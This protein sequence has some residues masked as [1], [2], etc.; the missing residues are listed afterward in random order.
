MRTPLKSI[1]LVLT[2][3]SFLGASSPSPTHLF[4]VRDSIEMVRFARRN[5]MVIFSPD[6]K[7]FAIVTSRGII[8]SNE[9][10]STIWV[11]AT[12]AVLAFVRAGSEA[13]PPAPTVAARWSAIPQTEYFDSYEPV[14]SDLQWL[15]DSTSLLY[16][17]QNSYAEH[18]VYIANIASGMIRPL[19]PRGRDVTK[20]ELHYASNG[21]SVITYVA[22]PSRVSISNGDRL[23]AD[24]SDVTGLPLWQI[25]FPREEY[26]TWGYP[27]AARSYVSE[28]RG[29]KRKESTP[30][31]VS[32]SAVIKQNLNIP[33]ALWVTDLRT[34]K[35]KKLWDPNPHFTAMKFGTASIF[36]WRDSSGYEW[37][38]G[39][40]KPPDYIPGKRYPLVIQT[41]GFI[42]NEFMTDGVFTTAFAA[43]PLASAG[44]VVLE[45]GWNPNHFI[46]AQEIPDQIRGF[47]SA[48]DRLTSIGLVDRKRVGI[49]GFSRTCYHVEGALINDPQLF[50]AASI[51]D[52]VDESYVQYLLWG[53]SMQPL[54]KQAAN[55]SNVIYGA[56]PFGKGLLTWAKDTLGFHLN[57]IQTP[58]LIGALG[59]DSILSEWEIYSSLRMQKKPVDLIYIPD[60]QHILQKPLDRLA[61]QQGSVDWF[62]FWLQGYEDPNPTKAV[63]YRRWEGL[64]KLQE[65]N[66]ARAAMPETQ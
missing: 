2:L 65:A 41:H 32:L 59:R 52:G 34:K 33:P 30:L 57:R 11:F 18:Q 7:Y 28:I 4:A 12:D 45:M 66:E 64:R 17:V 37:V 16:L 47:K 23:N 26:R 27:V 35:T 5:P 44:I 62:R 31:A 40:V 39:L 46:T 61:S 56:T 20:L 1:F 21:N 13:Q 54:D 48:I 51:T 3:Y 43:K 38:A 14:I 22:V 58:V 42:A 63:Q 36:H 9:I 29:H 24:A 50:V 25:L 19:T 6:R 15:P 49:I 8:R 10:E 60:G 55:E 53:A